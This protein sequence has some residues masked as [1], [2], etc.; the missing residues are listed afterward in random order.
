MR[1]PEIMNSSQ[2]DSS[3]ILKTS[4]GGVSK[5][6]SPLPIEILREIR[7][8]YSQRKIRFVLNNGLFSDLYIFSLER[9]RQYYEQFKKSNSF[10]RLR[11]EV[12]SQEIL[13]EILRRY[14]MIIV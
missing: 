10:V 1:A 13:Y 6:E 12:I 3:E 14:N 2:N 4:D 11:D 7:A 5:M 9:L 8:G